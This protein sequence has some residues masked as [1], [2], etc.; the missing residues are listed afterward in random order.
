MKTLNKYTYLFLGIMLLG[1]FILFAI[2]PNFE[3]QEFNPD[4][5]QDI[6]ENLGTNTTIYTNDENTLE[7][8]P[9][10]TTPF[11]TDPEKSDIEKLLINNKAA[12]DINGFNSYLLIGSD[13]RDE[14]SSSSRG[15]ADGK[16]ADVIIIGLISK[17]T[18]NHY[19]LSIPRDT[20]IMNACT[21][22]IERINGSYSMNE[23]GNNAENLAAA[24][25]VITGISIDHFASF[26]FE[27]FENI[28]DSFYGIEICLDNTQREGYSFE[29]QKGCQ[30]VNGS[31]A[32]NW[33]V[34]RNTEILVGEKI[35][36][37]NGEDASEWKKMDGV[38]DLSRNERQQYVI[39]QLLKRLNDFQSLTELN[40]FIKTLEDSFVIDNNLTLNKAINILWNFRDVDFS[41]IN[42]HS[43]PT[44]PYEFEDGRQV[45]IISENFSVYAEEI[46]LISS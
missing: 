11:I 16:R 18:D 43:I 36:D 37:E 21:N 38:S 25:K 4:K 23:C 6:S 2:V 41:Q 24:V 31:T 35:L 5:V 32:L 28:I 10:T 20:L 17:T 45:L 30:I 19:L 22:E 39:L 33:V 8:S 3:T 15:F 46:G 26:N 1:L 34:S 42:K 27:G 29:L 13:E 7:E 44:S 40:N 9:D 14:N 12:F